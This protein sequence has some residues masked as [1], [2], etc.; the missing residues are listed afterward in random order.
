MSKSPPIDHRSVVRME[1]N[2]QQLGQ[3]QI[4]GIYY[5]VKVIGAA[6]LS[7]E[8]SPFKQTMSKIC[9]IAQTVLIGQQDIIRVDINASKATLYNEKV[10]QQSEFSMTRTLFLLTWVVRLFEQRM[11]S[12]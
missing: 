8:A 1:V 3:I 4:N 6:S 7:T 10:P 9:A 2:E 12:L 11:G 5:D